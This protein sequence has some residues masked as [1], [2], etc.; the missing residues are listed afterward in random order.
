MSTCGQGR[1]Y[2]KLDGS[3]LN[4]L[5]ADEVEEGL[6]HSSAV[7]VKRCFPSEQCITQ[8]RQ[9]VDAAAEARG[10]GTDG[11]RGLQ[12]VIAGADRVEH[13]YLNLPTQRTLQRLAADELGELQQ[14]LHLR[15][16]E[17]GLSLGCT[18]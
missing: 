13:R 8:Q 17:P 12:G 6:Q 11:W 3:A 16:G 10:D 9:R 1:R 14:R 18:C 15:Q 4:G 5:F 7:P 2:I